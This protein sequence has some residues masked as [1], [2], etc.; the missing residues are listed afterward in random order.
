MA[1]LLWALY[2]DNRDGIMQG[3]KMLLECERS[4]QSD[5]KS[6]YKFIAIA[7]DRATNMLI[8]STR[9]LLIIPCLRASAAKHSYTQTFPSELYFAK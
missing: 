5:G 8:H 7:F 3:W 6:S 9:R 4:I 2:A 1:L